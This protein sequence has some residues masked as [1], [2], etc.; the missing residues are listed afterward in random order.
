MI[1]QCANPSPIAARK[2]FRG[3]SA[4][5][6]FT[7]IEVLVTLVILSTGIVVVLQAFETSAVALSEARDALRA[8]GLINQVIAKLD[9]DGLAAVDPSGSFPAPM[10]GFRWLLS[11]ADSSPELGVDDLTCVTV[12]VWREPSGVHHTTSTYRHH[13]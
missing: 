6:A 1:G 7:L 2:G 8:T 5:Q 13:P 9:A 3:R 12:E 4:R 10:D 11:E